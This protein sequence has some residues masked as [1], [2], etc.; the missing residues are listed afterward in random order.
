MNKITEF[1][2]VNEFGPCGSWLIEEFYR[3]KPTGWLALDEAAGF[4]R[5]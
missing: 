4:D 5:Q 1:P 3:M 2:I